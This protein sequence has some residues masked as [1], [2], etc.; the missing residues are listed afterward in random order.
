MPNETNTIALQ[1]I[2]NARVEIL[3]GK[4]QRIYGL[5]ETEE[6]KLYRGDKSLNAVCNVLKCETKSIIEKMVEYVS[7]YK[8]I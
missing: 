5:C 4:L 7:H 8:Y 3:L 6:K 1:D 2:G